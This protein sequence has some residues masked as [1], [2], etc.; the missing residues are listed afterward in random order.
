QAEDGIRDFHVTGVQTCALP[1]LMHAAQTAGIRILRR[2]PVDPGFIGGQFGPEGIVHEGIGTI[3]LLVPQH[4][5]VQK[6][7]THIMHGNGIDR[8]GVK[9]ADLFQFKRKIG[10]NQGMVVLAKQNKPIPLLPNQPCR[11]PRISLIMTNPQAE[12]LGGTS[13]YGTEKC[14]SPDPAGDRNPGS[15]PPP[16]TGTIFSFREWAPPQALQ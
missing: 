1:I 5:P 13:P 3:L 4:L 6:P 9:P 15:P 2:H 14:T 7:P 16:L 8:G 12:P 10:G 11:S